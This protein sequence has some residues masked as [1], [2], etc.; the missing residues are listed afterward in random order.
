MLH[1]LKIYQKMYDL[2][3]YAFPIINKMPRNSRFTLGQKII[4]EMLEIAM[5]ISW[6][7]RER[8]KRR[9]LWEIDGKLDQLRLLIRLAKDL[10]LLNYQSYGQMSE[11]ITEIG[12]LLGGWTKTCTGQG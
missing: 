3:L 10:T 2:I 8:D 6:A 11:R 1:E 4:D 12:R 9:T 7:N 5:M